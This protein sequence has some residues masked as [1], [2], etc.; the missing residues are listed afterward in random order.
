M[1]EV[2][3]FL[4]E[5]ILQAVRNLLPVKSILRES[6]QEDDDDGV[7][8]SNTPIKEDAKEDFAN[9]EG[10]APLRFENIEANRTRGTDVGM[11]DLRQE[12]DSRLFEGVI[13]GKS[14]GE[15]EDAAGKRGVAGPKE[16]A[17]PMK[18]VLVDGSRATSRGRI[19]CDVLEFFLNATESHIGRCEDDVTRRGFFNFWSAPVVSKKKGICVFL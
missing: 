8:I 12:L 15:L 2:G 17:L 14:D 9:R 4:E 13:G 3:R 11:I 6:L 10:R 5:G 19:L 16:H 7:E 1:N 18:Q